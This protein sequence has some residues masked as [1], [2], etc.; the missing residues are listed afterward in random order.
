MSAQTL[1][2]GIGELPNVFDFDID[3]FGFVGS[4][5]V[6]TVG[7]ES[8][9]DRIIGGVEGGVESDDVIGFDFAG[10]IEFERNRLSDDATRIRDNGTEND[11]TFF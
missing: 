1:N 8:L 7:V 4:E 3:N 6:G 9:F 2:F 11:T 5:V 10:E